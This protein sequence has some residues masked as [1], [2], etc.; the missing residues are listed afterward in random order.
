MAEP[1]RS[2]SHPLYEQDF[3]AWTEEQAALLEARRTVG[4]D[5]ANLAE[6][7]RTL[8]RSERHAISGRLGILLIHLLK[9]EFQ[10]DRR[11]WSR[12]A[13]I[14]E[15][16]HRLR[17]RLEES[18]SLRSYLEEVLA[19]EYRI[20][21]LKASGE[22]GLPLDRFPEECPYTIAE[23]LDDDFQPGPQS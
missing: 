6:E 4:V 9:W 23:I 21:R 19:K 20:A 14:F 2:A 7:I 12:R 3:Y 5:W 22:T 15:H 17:G 18:P 10:V 8:G 11:S 16:R 1:A 13:N